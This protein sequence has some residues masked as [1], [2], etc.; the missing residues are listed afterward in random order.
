MVQGKKHPGL[1]LIRE[2][3]NFT[4]RIENLEDSLTR[5]LFGKHSARE[6]M[7]SPSRLEKFSRCP[8][9]HFVHYGLA[10]EERRIFE[11]SGREAGDVYHRCLMLLAESLTIK[12][13]DL[14]HRDLPGCGLRE[15]ECR[16]KV[17]ELMEQVRQNIR[18]VCWN[19]VKRNDIV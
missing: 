2:G 18:K 11:V 3:I 13:M 6:F 15:E 17:G 4:N 12:G 9:A 5:E 19:K 14:N 1:S 10:P 7:I 8:F 16:K